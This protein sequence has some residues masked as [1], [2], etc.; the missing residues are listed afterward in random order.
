VI[1]H[2]IDGHAVG[3]IVEIHVAGLGEGHLEIHLRRM[4]R[5]ADTQD[6]VAVAAAVAGQAIPAGIG[7]GELGSMSPSVRPA[8]ATIG[9]TVEPGGY[10]PCTV[11]LNSGTSGESRRRGS[12]DG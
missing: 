8:S 4:T 9:L 5:A 7:D 3:E 10:W 2:R 6:P 1:V 12:P 11:R